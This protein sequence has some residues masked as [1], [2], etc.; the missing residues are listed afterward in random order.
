MSE[1]LHEVGWESWVVRIHNGNV[2]PYGAGLGERMVM[3]LVV[4]DD[5]YVEYIGRGLGRWAMA[6]PKTAKKIQVYT[7]HVC[8][9]W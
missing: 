3:V 5:D 1:C 4:D 6:R 9:W 8:Q 7:W 2:L